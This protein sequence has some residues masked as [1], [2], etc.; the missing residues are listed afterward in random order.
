VL[1]GI[2]FFQLTAVAVRVLLYLGERG[3]IPLPSWGRKRA[4]A[5]GPGER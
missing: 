1:T 3:Q 5:D 2:I 4:R